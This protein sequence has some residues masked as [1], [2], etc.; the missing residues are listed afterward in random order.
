MQTS[1][2]LCQLAKNAF[3][4]IVEA[5]DEEH[6]EELMKLL[7]ELSS[8]WV[9]WQQGP[10]THMKGTQDPP[11]DTWMTS[12]LPEKLVWL[13]ALATSSLERLSPSPNSI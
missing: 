2:H 12:R 7:L 9:A 11:Q 5:D 4:T 10:L 6:D 13:A 8:R 1:A 3:D